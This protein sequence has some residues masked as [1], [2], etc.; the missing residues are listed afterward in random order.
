MKN[1]RDTLRNEWKYARS[2]ERKTSLLSRNFDSQRNIS[3]GSQLIRQTFFQIF[4]PILDPLFPRRQR[5]VVGCSKKRS[6]RPRKLR[7]GCVFP[8]NLSTFLHSNARLNWGIRN[9]LAGSVVFTSYRKGHAA[10]KTICWA[11]FQILPRNIPTI[12]GGFSKLCLFSLA[13][14][15]RHFRHFA[16]FL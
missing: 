16:S 15:F 8:H 12:G 1:T 6:R 7:E 13:S 11:H 4:R 10:N 5:G 2:A 9:D 14:K 3:L